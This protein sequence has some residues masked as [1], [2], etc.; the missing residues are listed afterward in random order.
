MNIKSKI[1]RI[2]E[3]ATGKMVSIELFEDIEGRTIFEHDDACE[4][5]A[6]AAHSDTS[7]HPGVIERRRV[8][9]KVSPI[10]SFH[11]HRVERFPG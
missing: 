3:D 5:A 7:V 8:F 6:S 11:D 10:D 9:Y 2:T 1:H 4:M